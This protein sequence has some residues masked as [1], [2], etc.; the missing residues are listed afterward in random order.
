MTR[1]LAARWRRYF[2]IATGGHMAMAPHQQRVVDE[3]HE[4]DLKLDKLVEFLK[5]Q[6]LQS[7]PADEQERLTRQSV[8][9]DKYSGVL[10]ERIAHF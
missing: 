7:L 9:M 10:A 8:L 4:L 2:I 3:K 6:I 1:S 5:G